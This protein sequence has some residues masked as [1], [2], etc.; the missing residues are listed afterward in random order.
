[1]AER[2]DAVVV[3]GG[4]LGACCRRAPA[5]GRRP[6]E[7][8]LLE[9]DRVGQATSSAGAGFVGIWA[10]GYLPA[11]KDEEVEVERYGLDFYRRLAEEGYEFDYKQNGN[12]WAATS[13][14]G[15]A[16]LH[17]A[18]SRTTRASPSGGVLSP[19]EVEEVTGIIVAER[20]ARRRPLP[21][22]MSGLRA[23]GNGGGRRAFRRAGR[24]RRGTPPGRAGSWSRTAAWSPSRR[25][26]A[27]SHTSVAVLA[28][29][30]VDEPAPRSSSGSG[31]PWCRSSSRA[32]SRSRS[33]CRRRCRR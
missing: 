9:R 13:G 2:A 21:E 19:A 29:G 14:G 10:N 6:G 5:R 24:P 25:S 12:L 33:A 1:M 4:I 26:A 11:W 30:A 27:G 18:G 17:R 7:V 16:D 23:E 31:R 15:M 28:A 22:R 32:S 3:G 8:L 20:G